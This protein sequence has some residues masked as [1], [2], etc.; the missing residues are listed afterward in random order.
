MET[1]NSFEIAG[2]SLAAALLQRS[3]ELFGGLLRDLL[4]LF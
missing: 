2:K 4:D 3:D 1:S